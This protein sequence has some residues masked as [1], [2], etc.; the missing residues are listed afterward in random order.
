MSDHTSKTIMCVI[1]FLVTKATNSFVI[2]LSKT[3]IMI[4]VSD[5]CLY[6]I[7]GVLGHSLMT[8]A[9]AALLSDAGIKQ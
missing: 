2:I 3:L 1:P 5:N 4:E 6:I 9:M 8:G 7:R